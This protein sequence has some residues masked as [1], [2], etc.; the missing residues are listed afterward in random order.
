[1]G[2]GRKRASIAHPE[3]QSLGIRENADS[4]LTH[5]LL[6]GPISSHSG[7]PVSGIP[8]VLITPPTSLPALGL[9]DASP[10]LLQLTGSMSLLLSAEARVILQE[11]LITS[12]FCLNSSK[13]LL[14]SLGVK[15]KLL[16]SHKAYHLPFSFPHGVGSYLLFL[17]WS[18]CILCQKSR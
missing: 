4:M 8:P 11:H 14:C 7:Y 12:L 5:L 16:I 1:M 3:E 10:G 15:V 2:T 18:K 9:P 17:L 13:W 6:L